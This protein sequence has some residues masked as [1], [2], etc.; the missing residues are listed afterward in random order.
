MLDGA[1]SGDA[2]A[3]A[4]RVWGALGSGRTFSIVARD[5]DARR[6][7]VRGDPRRRPRWP[8]GSTIDSESAAGSA[9]VG[10]GR[11]RC[12]P[13]PGSRRPAGAE[14]GRGAL[15]VRGR[16]TRRVSRR[17]VLSSGLVSVVDVR[18]RFASRA[19]TTA[20]GPGGTGA[21]DGVAAQSARARSGDLAAYRNDPGSTA[22]F[23]VTGQSVR[24]A[25]QTGAGRAGWPV[26]RARQRSLD[27]R[28]R[29]SRDVHGRSSRPMRLSLEVRLPGGTRRRGAGAQFAAISTATPQ[30]RS[31]SACA[32]LEPRRTAAPSLRPIVARVQCRAAG[33]ST[34]VNAAPGASGES[35]MLR[36]LTLVIAPA[37][38]GIRLAQVRPSTSCRARAARKSTL[39][40]HAASSAGSRPAPPAAMKNVVSNQYA[41]ES[42]IASP[43]P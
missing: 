19:R 27:G 2:A 21:S 15:T 40:D 42:T 14:S 36:D 25:Y 34:R 9:S 30:R 39:V 37:L 41:N 12:P 16:G 5:R 28:G 22:S 43:M 3:D 1:L 29:R 35:W 26:R 17:G 38:S 4:E 11:R 13:G 31:S 8:M 10:P 32:S 7:G 6:A 23:D 18:T 33:R 20:L 24:F